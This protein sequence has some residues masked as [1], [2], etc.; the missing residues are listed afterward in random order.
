VDRC[1]VGVG[2]VD[3][4]DDKWLV[5]HS[6]SPCKGGVGIGRFYQTCF[7]KIGGGGQLLPPHNLLPAQPQ[8]SPQLF[9]IFFKSFLPPTFLQRFPGKL[10]T[11]LQQKNRQDPHWLEL[12]TLW[13][14]PVERESVFC[15]RVDFA[16]QKKY[17]TVFL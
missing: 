12:I 17:A 7:Q 11:K 4:F 16:T 14:L 3:D 2:V 8:I 10:E 15:F 9:L 5:S 1:G 13:I 6:V